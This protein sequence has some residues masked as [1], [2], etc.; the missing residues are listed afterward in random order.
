MT[1]QEWI[2]V[3]D[4]VTIRI[5]VNA[6]RGVHPGNEHISIAMELLFKRQNELEEITVGIIDEEDK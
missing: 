6:L 5:A 2:D 3:T 4:L 1:E